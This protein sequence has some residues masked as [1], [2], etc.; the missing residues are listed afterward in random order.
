ARDPAGRTAH[1]SAEWFRARV[2]ACRAGPRHGAGAGRAAAAAEHGGAVSGRLG[3]HLERQRRVGPQ[4]RYVPSYRQ[5]PE[6][7]HADGGLAAE[8]HPR[9][10]RRLHPTGHPPALARC[11]LSPAGRGV[12]GEGVGLL[13]LL[14]P[15]D[16]KA[17][18]PTDLSFFACRWVTS[19]Y[20]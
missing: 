7:R 9:A 11:S 15:Q 8:A 14:S 17:P 20:E 16:E 12:G 2:A 3:R 10:G 6:N 13:P 18:S 4:L 5:G 1:L 19:W